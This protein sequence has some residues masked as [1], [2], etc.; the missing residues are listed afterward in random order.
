MSKSKQAAKSVFIIIIFTVGSKILGYIREALIAAKFGSDAETDTFFVA[1]T[2]ISLFATIITVSINTTMIPVFSE[3]EAKEGKRAKGDHAN[4]LLNVIFMVSFVFIVLA[5]LLAPFIIR[6]LAS[7]FGGKQYKLA[8][9]MMRIGLPVVFFAGT[10]GVFEGYLQSELMFTESAVARLPF[11]LIYIFFLIFLSSFFGIKGLMVASVLAVGAQVLTQIPGI[12]KAGFKYSFVLDFKDKYVRKIIY[13]APPTLIGIAIGDLN[14]IIDK[15]LAS[16]L[17]DGSISALNY[18]N[19]LGGLITGI[20]ISAITIV[21][22]PL[23]SKEANE[24]SNDGFKKIIIYGINIILSV[25]IPAIIG[26]IV[27][28][29]P[30]VRVAFERGAFDSNATCMTVGALIFYLIGLV[31]TALDI[32]LCKVYYSLQDTRTPVTVGIIA[33]VINIILNF[34]LINSMAHRGLALATSI[35]AIVT[36]LLLLYGLKKKIGPFGFTKSVKCGL[37]SLI[38]SIMMGVIIYF[39]NSA[40]TES[41]G[42]GTMLRLVVLLVSVGVGALIYF[43]LIYIFRIDEVDWIIKVVRDKLGEIIA[44]VQA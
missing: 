2:A 39:L 8:V 9:L 26:M 10:V 41:D 28:A 14:V 35:S 32:L 37:K 13:L 31:G 21:I 18:A 33:V 38:A 3:I 6:I 4:N 15:S 36:S 11:N 29:D 19:I 23:L 22:F 24:D 25:M 30:I 27:L 40:L 1:F 34:A 17:A 44:K 7:G 42:D 5:W 12:R 20:F 43:M 16:T